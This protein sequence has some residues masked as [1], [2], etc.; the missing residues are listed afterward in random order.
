MPCRAAP[1]RRHRSRAQLRGN[2]LAGA[3]GSSAPGRRLPKGAWHSPAFCS[4]P[5]V[6]AVPL[7][8]GEEEETVVFHHHYVPYPGPAPILAWPV[9]AQDQGPAAVRYLGTGSLAEDGEV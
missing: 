5:Q 2:S 8:T 4:S 3:L 9:P 7:Q 6:M 1:C